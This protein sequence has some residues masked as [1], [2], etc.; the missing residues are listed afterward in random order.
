[1]SSSTLLKCPLNAHPIKLSL[2]GICSILMELSLDAETLYIAV[3]V[4][5]RNPFYVDI[6]KQID[7]DAALLS[8]KPE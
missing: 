4:E 3:I 8:E 1:M 6:Q 5:K 7:H 2:Q